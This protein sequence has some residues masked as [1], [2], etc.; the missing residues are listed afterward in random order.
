MSRKIEEVFNL[1]P[2]EEID[3]NEIDQPVT[4]DETGFNLM[5]L[6]HTLDVADKIDQAL[7]VVRDLETLL[8]VKSMGVTR[9]G[10]SAT[11]AILDPAREQLGMDPVNLGDGSASS[12]Y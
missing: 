10:A 11:A 6:Q 3:D 7:P 1:P 4:E 12:N 8:K 5:S 9:V 2:N